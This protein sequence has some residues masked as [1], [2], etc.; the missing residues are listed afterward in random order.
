MNI[1]L[2]IPTKNE[3]DTIGHLIDEIK[4]KC[5]EFGFENVQI[6]IT[7]DSRDKT[8]EIARSKGAVIVVG[9]G[10]GLGSAMYKGLKES[11]K[12]N[13]D[14]IYSLDADGQVDLNEIRTFKEAL[15]EN[16][17]DLVLG[18]RFKKKDLIK[19][20][21][22]FINRTGI[23]VLVR[24]LNYLTGLSLTDSHGGIRA[25]KP[26][27]V[28][29]LEII[30]THTYVQEAI[31][32]AYE[33]GYKVIEVPSAWLKRE[34]GKSRVV[35]SIP[36]YIFYTLPVL[37]LRSGGHIQLLFPMGLLMIL[38]AFLDI[39]YVAFETGFSFMEMIERQSFNLFILLLLMGINLFFFGFALELIA[40][41]KRKINL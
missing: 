35:L 4:S 33:N 11:L 40:N 8:R 16:N 9:G 32:D 1:A 39:T 17:A 3:A 31:I 10:K 13:P 27:V 30:G 41:I 2:V 25:M 5:N 14:I 15:V 37:I 21:Y 28:E 7:D 23:K 18:S 12:F 34:H 20:E 6:I 26:E 22:K 36:K 19:Y 38:L 29:S 24:I